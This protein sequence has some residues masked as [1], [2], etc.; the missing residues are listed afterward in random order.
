MPGKGN[1]RNQFSK[2]RLNTAYGYSGENPDTIAIV[3][4]GQ[5]RVRMPA[6]QL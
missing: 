6:K 2:K 4:G 5:G 3:S 1:I